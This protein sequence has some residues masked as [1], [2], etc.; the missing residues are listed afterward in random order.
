MATIL[1]T[2]E[3]MQNILYEDDE[4]AEIISNKITDHDRWTVSYKLIFKQDNK[5]YRTF[6]S[7]GATE[8]Q[9]ESPWQYEAEVKCYEVKAVEKTVIVYEDVED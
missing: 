8:Q 5:F 4:T 7:V 9:D 2:K 1:K 6:Y 3:E